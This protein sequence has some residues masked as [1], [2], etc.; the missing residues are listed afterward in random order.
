MEPRALTGGYALVRISPGTMLR[1]ALAI[2]VVLFAADLALTIADTLGAPPRGVI[3]QEL[4]GSLEANIPTWYSSVLLAGCGLGCALVGATGGQWARHW[5]VLGV[6]LLAASMDEV[7]QLHERVPGPLRRALESLGLGGT[8]S[9]AAAVGVVGAALLAMFVAYLPWLRA[10]P[11]M[12]RVGLLA[13]ATLYV[14][15]ALGLEVV[16][17][18]TD[19]VGLDTAFVTDLLSAVE[20]FGEKVGAGLALGTVFAVLLAGPPMPQPSPEPAG[21][22]VG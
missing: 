20:E 6:V 4:D 10:L 17:R 1:W 15:S 12:T 3:V 18:M 2:A 21:A 22:M 16:N 5:T 19:V 11:R 14:G 9:R 13:A 8:G 7:A